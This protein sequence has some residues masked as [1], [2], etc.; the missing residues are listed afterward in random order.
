MI[1]RIK[2][3][4]SGEK[5]FI[6]LNGYYFTRIDFYSDEHG[7]IFDKMSFLYHFMRNKSRKTKTKGIG[8]T[9]GPLKVLPCWI[10][11]KTFYNI[12]RFFCNYCLI[13]YG[14]RHAMGEWPSQQSV[15]LS[16]KNLYVYWNMTSF[17]GSVSV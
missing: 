6:L 15:V 14:K 8:F 5:R 9:T 10:W 12:A 4:D 11:Y 16:G 17:A 3:Y 2:K 1:Q 7:V 13:E